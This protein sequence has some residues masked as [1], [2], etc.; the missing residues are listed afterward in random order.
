VSTDANSK[1]ESSGEEGNNEESSGE[2][3]IRRGPQAPST[4]LTR[5]PVEAEKVAECAHGYARD[6]D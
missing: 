5:V 6:D 4:P 1:E 3:E 2:E